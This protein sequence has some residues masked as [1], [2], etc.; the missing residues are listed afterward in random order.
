MAYGSI[1]FGPSVSFH[2]PHYYI[3][4]QGWLFHL[5]YVSPVAVLCFSIHPN[6]LQMLFRE[7][8]KRRKIGRQKYVCTFTHAYTTAVAKT[9]SSVLYVKCT[10]SMCAC[11]QMALSQFFQSQAKYTCW[12]GFWS[13]CVSEWVRERVD[14]WVLVRIK[15]YGQWYVWYVQCGIAVCNCALVCECE[16][17]IICV[18]MIW[19]WRRRLRQFRL[20]SEKKADFFLLLL[21][22]CWS[23]DFK[24][25]NCNRTQLELFPK[26]T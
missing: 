23:F 25:I 3:M 9:S 20:Y 11:A 12:G 16:W 24:P 14:V 8:K 22:S 6:V 19:W 18:C 10:V 15:L 7:G 26:I 1:L 4:A 5:V 13:M 21:V 17:N 2:H